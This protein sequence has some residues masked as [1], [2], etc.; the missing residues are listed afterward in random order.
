MQHERPA[1][2]G[3]GG[4]SLAHAMLPRIMA[5]AR[6]R[7]P[8]RS[9]RNSGPAWPGSD[10]T[11]DPPRRQGLPQTRHTGRSNPPTHTVRVPAADKGRA[12]AGASAPTEDP[13]RLHGSQRPRAALFRPI[14]VIDGRFDVSFSIAAS[15]SASLRSPCSTL[16]FCMS[17]Y[18]RNYTRSRKSSID[19]G[20][21]AD[22]LCRPGTRGIRALNGRRGGRLPFY[23][24][25]HLPSTRTSF[26]PC[27]AGP[28]GRE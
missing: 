14:R 22:Y 17:H 24:I 28:A 23:S 1:T 10:P 25:V 5:V 8:I 13:S 20:S 26:E 4:H 18:T 2:A 21:L 19:P 27:F 15:A 3:W 11:E 7:G 9:R 6:H 12:G 16:V